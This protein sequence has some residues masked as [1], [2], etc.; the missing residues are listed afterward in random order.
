MPKISELASTSFPSLQHWFAAE[1]GGES[2]KLS[3]QQIRD[4]LNYVASELLVNSGG[5]TTIE[6]ALASLG[7]DKAAT[8]YV[9]TQDNELA[10]AISNRIRFDASQ[11]LSISEQEQALENLGVTPFARTILDDTTGAAMWATMGASGGTGWQRTPDGEIEQHGYVVNPG[12]D[13]EITFPIAF[14]NACQSVVLTPDGQTIGG[15]ANMSLAYSVIA[16]QTTFIVVPRFINDG[17]S[18]GVA[19]QNYYWQAKGY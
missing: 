14:P 1:K 8:S 2:V 12:G 5:T 19:T 10:D 7:N 11:T 16:W 3:I 4:L 13:H 18:V 9:D 15:Q 6:Q 17:G